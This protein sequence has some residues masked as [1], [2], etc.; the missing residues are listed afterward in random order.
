MEHN[1][2]PGA[3]GST[4]SREVEGRGGA[5]EGSGFRW[6]EER[7]GFA[8]GF[9]KEGRTGMGGLFLPH[10]HL[11]RSPGAARALAGASAKGTCGTPCGK[12]LSFRTEMAEA[13]GPAER[14]A[15]GWL[16]SQAQEP[17]PG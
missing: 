3:K 14:G 16:R 10:S 5:V 17:G 9:D 1:H 12:S 2:A 4:W 15:H 13:R 11:T 7:T 6:E 8:D